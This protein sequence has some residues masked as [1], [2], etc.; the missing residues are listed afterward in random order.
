MPDRVPESIAAGRILR[1]PG[2]GAP[3]DLHVAIIDP[4]LDLVGEVLALGM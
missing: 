1:D 2:G 3:A 4:F